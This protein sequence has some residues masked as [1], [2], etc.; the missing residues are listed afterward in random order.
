MRNKILLLNLIFFYCIPLSAEN[1]FIQSKNVSLNKKNQTTIFKDEVIVKTEDGI[2]IKSDYAEYDKEKAFLLLKDNIKAIDNKNNIIETNYAEYDEKTKIFNSRGSTT[3]LTSEKYLIKGE[4]IIFDNLKNFIMSNKKTSIKDQE[5]NK[6]FLENFEYQAE[7]NIF[8]SVGLARVE[9]KM[10]NSY[11]FSQIYIDTKKKEI[12]GTDIKAFMNHQDFKINKKNKPRIFANS[13]KLDKNTNYFNKGIFTL[14]D[15]RPNDKCPPWSIQSSKILHDKRKKTIYYDNSVLKI[16]DIPILYLP[17]LSHPDPTVRRRSGF[18]PPSFSDTK[19]LG[20]GIS[21]PYFFALN[22]DK[23]FT[24]TSRFY[25]SENP[26]FIGAYHQAF[27]KSNLLAD[28]G[29][30]EGY[31]NVNTSKRGG[32]K[33][34]FFSKFT[35][36]FEGKN[37]SKNSLSLSFQN[38]SN[39]KYL[40]LY[41]IKSDLVDYNKDTLESSIEFTSE[42]DDMFLGFNATVFETLKEDYNDKY[43]YIL[44]EMTID[45]NLFSKD[46]IGILELQTNLKGHNYDTN[47]YSNFLINDFNFQSRDFNFNSGFK[48]TI[49][50]NIKNI[51]YE[52]KNI[53]LYKKDPT[54]EIFGALGL[55]SEIKL[56]KQEKKGLTHFLTPKLLLRLSPGSMRKEYSGSRLDPNSAFGLSRLDNIN[57]YET[58]YTGTLGL[59]YKVKGDNKEFDLSLA[60]IFNKEENKMMFSKT[61][62]DEKVSDLV[63][64]ANYSINDKIKLNYNFSLDQNYNDM[65]YNELGATFSYDSFEASFDFLQEK[66][67]IGNQ[68]YYKTKFKYYNDSGVFSFENKKNLITNSSEYY[69]LSYEYLNDC[70]RAGIVYRREFYN[71]SEIEPENSLMFKITI[72]PFGDIN[73]PSFN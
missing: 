50:A 43:E 51:N 19:N 10:N 60:Q 27:E 67:H 62:L 24:L 5:N 14:C 29:Y 6:I 47:K 41:K 61:S 1:I 37:K 2:S 57:N 34:H 72:S 21:I 8:K 38:V 49:L 32:D 31:K 63:G 25:N 20:F 4:D 68:E 16:Y 15:Y 65:N 11:E 36:N 17:K 12:L 54:S 56:K 46:D 39:D 48:S 73:S 71:D 7:N 58:G 28:F 66:K 33:S 40:K 59:D 70:L 44:P 64:S 55:L 45:K 30:T 18:L 52:T 69:D 23:N 53:D 3:I 22:E 13:V 26:L 42:R 35:K 9:D